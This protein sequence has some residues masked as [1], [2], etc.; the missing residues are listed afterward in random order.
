VKHG[1][2]GSSYKQLV[3]NQAIVVS[4]ARLEADFAGGSHTILG[5]DISVQRDDVERYRD[6]V[7]R[8][9]RLNG[10]FWAPRSAFK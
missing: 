5:V 3:K 4:A 7:L 9:W 8:F 6:S 2:D 10:S 1:G